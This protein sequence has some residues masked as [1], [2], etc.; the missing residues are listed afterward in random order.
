MKTE[1]SKLPLIAWDEFDGKYALFPYHLLQTFDDGT[2]GFCINFVGDLQIEERDALR[3]FRRCFWETPWSTAYDEDEMVQRRYILKCQKDQCTHHPQLIR[4]DEFP[5]VLWGLTL[6][7]GS[8]IGCIC[9][10][11]MAGDAISNWL[12]IG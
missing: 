3:R 6:V 7:L 8:F 12:G 9:L 10:V 1:V 2:Q 4:P 11:Y 5:A